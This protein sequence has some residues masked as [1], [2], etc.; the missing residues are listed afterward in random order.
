MTDENMEFRP[1]DWFESLRLVPGS[2]GTL[3]AECT[4]YS[5]VRVPFD[6]AINTADPQYYL[7]IAIEGALQ[8]PDTR[9]LGPLALYLASIKKVK[10]VMAFE[11]TVT[12]DQPCHQV[13]AEMYMKHYYNP[14]AED[15]A[16]PQHR[17]TYQ[18]PLLAMN[19]G[20]FRRFILLLALL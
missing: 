8:D 20:R 1:L 10:V 18:F 13:G 3:S 4:T 14:P 9:F 5:S 17:D 11:L 7:D 2:D 16:S 6:N 19:L 12:F 15:L